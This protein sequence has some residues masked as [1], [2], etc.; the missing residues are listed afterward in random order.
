MHI[1][2]K[3]HSLQNLSITPS[4][5]ATASTA[6]HEPKDANVPQLV[7]GKPML[8]KGEYAEIFANDVLLNDDDKHFRKG[9]IQIELKKHR[10]FVNDVLVLKDDPSTPIIKNNPNLRAKKVSKFEIKIDEEGQ[11][12][13]VVKTAI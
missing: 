3:K 11:V 9:S 8:V 7:K 10:L 13:Y 12:T 5:Q 1:K 2:G 4:F 6:K